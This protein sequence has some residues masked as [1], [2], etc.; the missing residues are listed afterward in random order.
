MR[1]FNV[2][3]GFFVSILSFFG[4]VGNASAE[5]PATVTSAI[6]AAGTDAATVAAAVL[7]V[8]VSL[9]AFHFM[10]REAK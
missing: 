6:T 1:V 10:R 9:L 8:V 4:L 5:V 7:V 2:I 3:T